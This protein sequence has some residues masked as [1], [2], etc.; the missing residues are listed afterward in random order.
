[1]SD[2][3]IHPAWSVMPSPGNI[4]GSSR[5]KELL[6]RLSW[7]LLDR[8]LKAKCS[9]AKSWRLIWDRHILTPLIIQ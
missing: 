7:Y 4:H 3:P 5:G 2:T 9:T 6:A 8:Y 1:M